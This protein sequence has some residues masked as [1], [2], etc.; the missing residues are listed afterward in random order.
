MLVMG[1]FVL[2]CCGEQK[3]DGA[4]LCRI[5]ADLCETMERELDVEEEG[6]SSGMG[7]EDCFAAARR[8][9]VECGN[10]LWQPVQSEYRADFGPSFGFFPP[11]SIAERAAAYANAPLTLSPG[12]T[13]VGGTR[14]VDPL[15]VVIDNLEGDHR[16]RHPPLTFALDSSIFLAASTAIAACALCEA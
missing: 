6:D 9:W 4:A 5:R 15:A 2:R 8:W 16:S 7:E 11:I 1:L 10:T 12:H 3:G 14:G 13:A